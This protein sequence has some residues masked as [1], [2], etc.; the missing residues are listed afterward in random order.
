VIGEG[1]RHE[2]NSLKARQKT[3]DL[4]IPVIKIPTPI[5]PRAAHQEQSPAW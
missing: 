3:P 4:L 1:E 5:D 2:E